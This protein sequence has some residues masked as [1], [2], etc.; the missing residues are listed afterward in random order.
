MSTACVQM[1]LWLPV[2]FMEPNSQPGSQGQSQPSCWIL[3]LSFSH[4]VFYWLEILSVPSHVFPRVFLHWTSCPLWKYH[5]LWPSFNVQ[6]QT[7]KSSPP[8]TFPQPFWSIFIFSSCE[9]SGCFLYYWSHFPYAASAFSLVMESEKKGSGFRTRC[10]LSTSLCPPPV[11][12]ALSQ[13]GDPHVVWWHLHT[14][15]LN[16]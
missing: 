7:L 9:I 10:E 1:P 4:T 3:V 6:D 2:F 14:H 8:P 5:S 13:H 15:W 16:G 11:P 12:R